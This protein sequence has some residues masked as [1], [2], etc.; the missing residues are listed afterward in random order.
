VQN[1]GI[2]TIGEGSQLTPIKGARV[3]KGSKQPVKKAYAMSRGAE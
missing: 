3:V 1:Q 2:L